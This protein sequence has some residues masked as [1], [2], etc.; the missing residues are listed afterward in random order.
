MDPERHSIAWMLLSIVLFAGNV[1]VLR[2]LTLRAPWV[3]GYVATVFRGA[4]GLVIVVAGFG[5]RGFQPGHLRRPLV[6]ARGA[7][8]A[9]GILLFYLTIPHLG[10]GRSVILNLTFP[11]FGAV[12]AAAWLGEV[13]TRRQLGWMLASLLGL[14]IFLGGDA[15][16]GRV[17][18]Y[19]VLGLLG[20]VTAGGA[21]VLIRLLRH[22]EHPATV[23]A[24]QCVWSLLVALPIAAP[25]LPRLTAGL[26]AGLGVAAVLV[27][28]AQLAMTHAFRSL[29]VA[30]GSAIQMLL[31]LLTTTGGVLFFGEI[32]S[33]VELAGAALTVWG[34]AQSVRPT[35]VNG[36]R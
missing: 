15:L 35:P 1:L 11:I 6:L 28:A 36:R 5:G 4:I 7:V 18:G 17:S 13:L 26:V 33:A 10:A 31:P 2:A 24:S 23:Y 25:T 16:K 29:S 27:G 32:L 8:G 20:A 21:V 30:R 9:A 12:M 14:A 19:E 34:T 22:S 3:D